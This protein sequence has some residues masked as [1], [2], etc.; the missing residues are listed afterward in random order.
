MTPDLRSKF[1]EQKDSADYFS[2]IINSLHFFF[3]I[4][5]Q[6]S[7]IKII[8]IFSLL[9]IIENFLYVYLRQQNHNKILLAYLLVDQGMP[10]IAKIESVECVF[11]N[12][13]NFVKR[14]LLL[15]LEGTRDG[16]PWHNAVQLKSLRNN[17]TFR[18]LTQNCGNPMTS[19]IRLRYIIQR[20]LNRWTVHQHIFFETF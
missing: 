15:S 8:C 16:M 13:Y 5:G 17:S 19:K 3:F 9:T 14:F 4:R 7:M 10:E 2:Q 1:L 12:V 6:Y 20:L 11:R 18:Y